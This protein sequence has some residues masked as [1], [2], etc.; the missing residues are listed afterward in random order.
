MKY[1]KD[2]NTILEPIDKVSVHLASHRG[3]LNFVYL[4]MREYYKNKAGYKETESK[5]FYLH[6]MP[7]EMAEIAVTIGRLEAVLA[8]YL[9]QR[10]H[11]EFRDIEI[12]D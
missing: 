1:K 3:H 9:Q 5:A 8:N 4:K 12:K 11:K 7:V 2:E 10:L 6:D